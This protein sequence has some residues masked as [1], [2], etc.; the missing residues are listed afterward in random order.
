MGG[1]FEVDPLP[2][3]AMSS[4]R[5]LLPLFEAMLSSSSSEELSGQAIIRTGVRT[6]EFLS[7]SPLAFERLIKG[8]IGLFSSKQNLSIS[9]SNERRDEAISSLRNVAASGRFCGGGCVVGGSFCGIGKATKGRSIQAKNPG[10]EMSIRANLELPTL[11]AWP[12]SWKVRDR[13]S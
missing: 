5:L 9:S 7:D 8:A 3:V 4:L 11:I 12:M 6:P 10:L 1:A 2:L 13:G